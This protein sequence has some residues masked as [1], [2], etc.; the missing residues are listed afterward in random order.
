MVK[1]WQTTLGGI[2]AILSA[3]VNIIN[4]GTLA[5]TDVGVIAAGVVGLLAKDKGVSG[6]GARATRQP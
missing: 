6:A 5:P 2:S 1:N 3:V 4:N